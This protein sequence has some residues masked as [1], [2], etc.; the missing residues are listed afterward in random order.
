MPH[1][2]NSPPQPGQPHRPE[3]TGL[4]HQLC[5]GLRE[6]VGIQRVGKS[7]Q[8]PDH[9]PRLLPGDLTDR[10][11]LGDLRPAS[12]QSRAARRAGITTRCA[13]L[14]RQSRHRGLSTTSS[15]AARVLL[16]APATGPAPGPGRSTAHASLLETGE[17]V[18]R[19][20]VVEL[21]IHR[22]HGRKQG[23]LERHLRRGHELTRGATTDIRVT[24]NP[25]VHMGK[26]A[27]PRLQ[28]GPTAGPSD[29]VARCRA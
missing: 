18:G 28:A 5:L 9:H 14:G 3:L 11:S 17:R 19:R 12:T 13:G 22:P 1:L 26:G 8:R 10:R 2:Q 23:V 20:G 16:D 7:L 24:T 15:A 29:E 25:R 27:S 21:V 4:G 6:E